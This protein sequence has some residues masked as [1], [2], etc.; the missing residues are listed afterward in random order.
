[1]DFNFRA[2]DLPLRLLFLMTRTFLVSPVGRAM[3]RAGRKYLVSTGQKW[4]EIS[5]IQLCL[6]RLDPAFDGY[7]LVQI[8]DFHI[9][10]W[11]NRKRLEEAILEV[12]ELNPDMVAITGDFVTR[13]PEEFEPDLLHLL[14]LLRSTDGV[15]AVLGNHD[16][17]TDALIVRRIL[18]NS[19]VIELNN[20]T[21]TIHR[22]QAQ[23]HFAGVDDILEEMDDLE[24]VLAGL[25]GSGAA[26][27]LAHEP[28]FADISARSGRFDLQ[29]SGHTH[30][31]QVQIPGFG[32]LVLPKQGRKYPCGMYQINGM[33][34]YT[35]RGL[36]TADIQLRYN[37]PAEV[38]VFDL[39][40]GCD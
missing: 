24:T 3:R 10:T 33:K 31:G 19:G 40:V 7:R 6:S 27:L 34:L 18:Q 14:R 21:F 38:T 28:D 9:G 29:I 4:L 11:A 1:M 39:R 37:C 12:N 35:N 32:P 23:L 13:N 26:I 25:P 15:V 36:G 22:G 5:H 2:P 17:W 16:H 8:S 30:G 20:K